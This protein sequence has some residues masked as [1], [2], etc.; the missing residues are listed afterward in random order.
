MRPQDGAYNSHLGVREVY[1]HEP[2][3]ALEADED[4]LKIVMKILRQAALQLSPRGILVMD[5]GYADEALM[6][7]LPNIPFT[8]LDLQHG[9]HGIS[10]LTAED[11]KTCR[12]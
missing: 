7:R 3:M 5:V 4:G 12:V 6:Q 8:W 11:L 1:Q 9:D 10:L 2:R